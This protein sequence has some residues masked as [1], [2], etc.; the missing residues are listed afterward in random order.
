M[1]KLKESL[2]KLPLNGSKTALGTTASA[3][4]LSAPLFG[5]PLP[6]DPQ[7]YLITTV[8]TALLGVLHKYLKRKYPDV[9]W[10]E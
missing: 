4:G 1:K 5:L 9:K 3:Y 10:P 6:V 8:A 2:D 7:T